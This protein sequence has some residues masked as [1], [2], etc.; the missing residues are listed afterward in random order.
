[1]NERI[2]TEIN[3]MFSRYDNEKTRLLDEQK[4]A[5]AAVA[6][7]FYCL[8]LQDVK[9]ELERFIREE[10]CPGYSGINVCRDMIKYIDNLNK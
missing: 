8:A 4:N 1:M 3:K 2:E 5:F 10:C 7:Y 9:I 6:D